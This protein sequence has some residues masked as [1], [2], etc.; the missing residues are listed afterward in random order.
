MMWRTIDTAPKDGT[1]IL[2][3]EGWVIYHVWW[4]KR[5]RTWKTLSGGRS[6]DCPTHWMPVPE[7]P[8]E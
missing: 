1:E 6:I 5:Y 2:V 8:D 4:L 7:P 3:W